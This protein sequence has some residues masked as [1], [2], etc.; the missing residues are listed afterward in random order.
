MVVRDQEE[1]NEGLGYKDSREEL[2]RKCIH[3]RKWRKLI[4]IPTVTGIVLNRDGVVLA[5]C[6]SAHHRSRYEDR[7]HV[8]R[9]S[10]AR[11]RA[12][13]HGQDG[14]SLPGHAH[15][16]SV[17]D[18]TRSH[19]QV[20]EC[21][22]SRSGHTRSSLSSYWSITSTAAGLCTPFAL[23]RALL[24]RDPRVIRSTTL[25]LGHPITRI[26]GPASRTIPRDA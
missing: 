7:N 25:G 15:C 24:R 6:L 18:R 16:L 2:S 17:C 1:E 9:S 8:V 13:R 22:S 20:A 5:V 4:G 12:R 23:L 21:V 19:H 26:A 14:S 11:H 3:K 10:T